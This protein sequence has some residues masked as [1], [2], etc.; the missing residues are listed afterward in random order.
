MEEKRKHNICFSL[1]YSYLSFELFSQTSCPSV[2]ATVNC[3]ARLPAAKAKTL[4]SPLILLLSPIFV[5]SVNPEGHS[6]DI[7]AKLTTSFELLFETRWPQTCYVAKGDLDLRLLLLCL[8]NAGMT[9]VYP[10]PRSCGAGDCRQ[11]FAG[12]GMPAQLRL[13][14]GILYERALTDTAIRTLSR[15]CLHIDSSHSLSS[16]LKQG[17]STSVWSVCS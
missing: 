10:T 12:R 8:W 6:I 5:Q 3:H 1:V 4:M 16:K 15:W 17:T 2:F 7:F 11:S 13:I 14:T 9:S